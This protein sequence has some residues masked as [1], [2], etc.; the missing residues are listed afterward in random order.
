MTFHK[1]IGVGSLALL[2]AIL[3]LVLSFPIGNQDVLGDQLLKTI[4]LKACSN[5]NDGIHY[6][7]FYSLAILVGAM[8]LGYLFKHDFG[9]KTGRRIALS[10]FIFIL[11]FNPLFK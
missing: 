6:T 9:A 2:L 11:L 5:G 3:G 4:G 8:I 1:K 7:M 10:L